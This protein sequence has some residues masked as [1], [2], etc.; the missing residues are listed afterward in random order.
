MRPDQLR[1]VRRALAALL[2]L[3]PVGACETIVYQD[4][5]LFP[6]P[7]ATAGGFVGY[8]NVQN[9]TTV[10]GNCHSTLQRQ[11]VETAHASAWSTL[12]GLGANALEQWGLQHTTNQLGNPFNAPGGWGAVRDP[13][14]QDV[15]CESCHGPNLDHVRAPTRAN[16]PL[17]EIGGGTV[18]QP[19]ACSQCHSGALYPYHEEWARS[20]HGRIPSAGNQ[21]T[22]PSGRAECRGCHT[23][24]DALVLWGVLA[25]FVEK[26]SHVANPAQN[27]AITCAVCHDPHRNEI[28]GQ[29][30]HPI[31]VPSEEENLCMKCH[32]K[33]GTPELTT[34]RGPHSPEGPTLLG[35]AGAWLPGMEFP[36]GISTTHGSER[37][38]RLCAGCHV[39]QFRTSA[40][41]TGGAVSTGHTFEATPCVDEQG[42]PVPGPC[43]TQQQTYRS[44]TGSGCHGS[45]AVARSIEAAVSQRFIDLTNELSGLLQ[46]AHQ[47][48]QRRANQPVTNWWACR[49]TGN[50][51]GS[52]LHWATSQNQ[53]WTVALSSAWN[54]E[55][56]RRNTGGGGPLR[57]G[58][59]SHNP[60]LIEALL[61]TSIREM[62][63]EYNLP[64]VTGVSLDQQVG[65]G[66]GAK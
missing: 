32:Q 49:G 55:L 12:Q 26:R 25:E 58:Q 23:G 53:I 14:Y 16:W 48:G 8:G 61:R 27:V 30:R 62:R 29:L 35:F 34:F 50:C 15:Q 9:R 54:F 10:C 11:W 45:E 7:A 56:I 22:S 39:V 1:N 19:R 59:V 44:C 64:A 36:Q 2:L 52:P 38:P 46:R 5:P 3:L 33:R 18:Q 60:I 51:P 65:I 37:N 17:A 13:R 4:R 40:P 31:N 24:E 57:Q 21:A 47:D 20:A 43:P 63:R 28:P 42:L 41:G 6:D 66:G